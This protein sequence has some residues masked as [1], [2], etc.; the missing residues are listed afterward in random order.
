MINARIGF[1]DPMYTGLMCAFTN[2]LYAL[3]SK[4]DITLEPVFDEAI[5]EGRF[6][7]GGRIWL[8]YLIL[9]LIGFLITKPIRNILLTKIKRKNK[10]GPHY[11]RS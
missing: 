9:I 11:V 2:Q 1:Y 5:L 7:I 4:Y 6:S 3:I 8:L 10:G